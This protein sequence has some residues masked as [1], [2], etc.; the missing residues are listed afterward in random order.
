MAE[1]DMRAN[2]DHGGG[3][4]P[5]DVHLVGS[6][7]VTDTEQHARRNNPNDSLEARHHLVGAG[8]KGRACRGS[9]TGK[10]GEERK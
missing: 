2:I 10:E 1:R 9:K 3:R 4:R 5:R 6:L 8:H 7:C